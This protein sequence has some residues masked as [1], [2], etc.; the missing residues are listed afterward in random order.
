MPP[1]FQHC[2][3]AL[4]LVPVLENSSDNPSIMFSKL[5]LGERNSPRAVLLK[6]FI[7]FPDGDNRKEVID[8][9]KSTWGMIQCVGSID[10]CHIPVM[11]PASN[12]TDYYKERNGILLYCKLS[13]I[14]STYLGI[15]V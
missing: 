5:F 9:F 10:D 8:G 6:I 3:L 15:S 11:P 1:I 12:H 13:W 14:K 7:K 2:F 4:V